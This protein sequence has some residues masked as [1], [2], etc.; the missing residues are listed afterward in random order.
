MFSI[1]YLSKLFYQIYSYKFSDKTN[2][3]KLNTNLGILQTDVLYPCAIVRRA[4]YYSLIVEFLPIRSNSSEYWVMFNKC[5]NSNVLRWAHGLLAFLVLQALHT[6][7]EGELRP[8]SRLT[9]TVKM[10]PLAVP[11]VWLHRS[12]QRCCLRNT[13]LGCEVADGGGYQSKQVF[14][15]DERGLY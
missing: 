6:L 9:G 11:R 13:K 1:R 15:A 12:Q 2:Y 5:K 7:G 4:E 10:K 3:H 14:K 8:W